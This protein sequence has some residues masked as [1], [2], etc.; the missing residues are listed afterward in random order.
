MKAIEFIQNFSGLKVENIRQLE[1]MY[2]RLFRFSE[3]QPNYLF[4]YVIENPDFFAQLVIWIF[5]RN[6]GAEEKNEELSLEKQHQR[7]ETAWELLDTLS[8]LPGSTGGN[9]DRDMLNSWV[10]VARTVFKES[11]RVGI[12]DSQIGTFLS[13]SQEGNDGIW[14]HESVR[15]VLERIKSEDIENGIE[16]GRI[17]ARGV[18]TRHPYAGGLQERKL[19]LSYQNDA[20]KIQ[21]LWP[22]TA[23]I[24]RSIAESYERC[25]DREDQSVEIGRY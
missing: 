19:A 9:I 17:S 12:G 1:W 22:R 14:P 15:D 18:T 3:V 4:K 5:K 11:G 16:C 6:D 13:G 25:A 7:A 21:L 10:D 24:L 8:M 23:S 2:L 20:E